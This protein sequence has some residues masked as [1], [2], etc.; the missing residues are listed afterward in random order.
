ML[1]EGFHDVPAGCVAAVVTHLEMRAPPAPRPAPDLPG[2]SFHRIQAPGTDWYRA[3]Y[4]RVGA[5]DWLWF[6]RLA[7]AEAALAVILKDPDV[8]VYTLRRDGQ[9]LALL[10]LDFRVPGECELA[11]FGVAPELIGTGAGRGLMTHAIAR[12]WARPIRRFHV[13]T[14]TLDH[15]AALGFYIRSGFTPTRR[16]IEIAPDPRLGGTLPDD[17]APQVPILR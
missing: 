7:M 6:S 5:Q 8:E 4:A 1:S 12:A 3:L 2:L 14:C 15:P 10:E 16:Q 17:A 13:H 9:D 11:F